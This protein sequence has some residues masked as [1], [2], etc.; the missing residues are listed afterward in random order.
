MAGWLGS[1]TPGAKLPMRR[2]E[3]AIAV[4]GR[5]DEEAN[6]KWNGALEERGARTKLLVVVVG[7]VL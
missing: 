3:P 2:L 5:L 4:V 6:A 7:C 1:G